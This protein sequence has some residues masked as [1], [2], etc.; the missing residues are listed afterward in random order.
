[1]SQVAPGQA[2]FA[3]TPNDTANINPTRGV[4]VGGTGTLKVDMADGSTVTFTGILAGQVHPLAVRRVYAT[5]TSAT[6]IIGIY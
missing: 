2:A 1:M 5:G 4:Y 6:T 3:I